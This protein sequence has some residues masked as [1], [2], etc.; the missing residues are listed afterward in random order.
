MYE[1]DAKVIGAYLK[2]RVIS[3]AFLL[4]YFSLQ[5]KVHLRKSHAHTIL[6]FLVFQVW[7]ILDKLL[8]SPKNRLPSLFIVPLCSLSAFPTKFLQNEEEE[9]EKVK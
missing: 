5:W 3:G 6:I 1:F 7:T 9:R 4:R 2:D 8:S